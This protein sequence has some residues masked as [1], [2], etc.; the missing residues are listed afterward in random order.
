MYTVGLDLK[1]LG[2]SKELPERSRTHNAY[3]PSPLP[4][5]KFLYYTKL[6][7]ASVLVGTYFTTR[8]KLERVVAS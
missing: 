1:A 3:D 4:H 6:L 7:R 2:R 5:L 8:T